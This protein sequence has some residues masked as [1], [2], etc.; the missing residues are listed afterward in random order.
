MNANARS[1][2]YRLTNNRSPNSS[3]LL[4]IS[5]DASLPY[6]EPKVAPLTTRNVLNREI[7]T[8]EPPMTPEGN[9]MSM[10]FHQHSKYNTRFGFGA[11][12]HHQN[13]PQAASQQISPT[14]IIKNGKKRG[15]VNPT[16]VSLVTMKQKKLNL[17]QQAEANNKAYASNLPNRGIFYD[18]EVK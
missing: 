13:S 17:Q 1:T 14:S 6:I 18:D 8:I 9:N 11:S 7:H 12:P 2:R 3:E 10:S 5:I 4:S 16:S 15:P